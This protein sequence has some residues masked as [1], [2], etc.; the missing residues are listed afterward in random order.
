MSTY[1]IPTG[2]WPLHIQPYHDL[3]N[4]LGLTEGDINSRVL[5]LPGGA[6]I[7]MRPNRDAVELKLYQT[8]TAAQKPVLGICRG[9]Q[10][11]LKSWDIPLLEHIPA[12][13]AE[14]IHTTINGDW[15]GE[16]SWHTTAQ[17]LFTNSRHHQG[18]WEYQ[19]PVL[20]KVIDKT[21]DGIVEA[22][23]NTNQF[24]V[25]WHPEH[26]EM[27]GTPAQEWWLNVARSVL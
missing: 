16:S 10:L 26:P 9:M 22:I 15:R 7:G 20:W 5:L 1:Y 27:G 2:N 19:I 23:G 17:G 18:F 11:M 6:D 12:H 25:Q 21:P 3:M 13:T 4:L 8:W 14:I 24:G